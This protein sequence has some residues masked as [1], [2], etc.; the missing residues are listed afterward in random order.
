MLGAGA[1]KG[2]NLQLEARRIRPGIAQERLGYVACLDYMAPHRHLVDVT[3]TSASMNTNI[4]HIGARPPLPCSLALGAQ[5]GKFDV[6][7]PTSHLLDTPSVQS[8]HD[9]CPFALEAGGRLAPTTVEMVDRVAIFVAVHRF[10]GMG[11]PNSRSLRS[12]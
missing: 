11:A 2:R 10:L 4:P 8:V 6:D 3:V 5:H 9:Y 12:I 7:L 1:T